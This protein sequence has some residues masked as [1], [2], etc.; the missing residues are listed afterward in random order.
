[1]T[2]FQTLLHSHI[3]QSRHNPHCSPILALAGSDTHSHHCRYWDRLGCTQHR[4]IGLSF[5]RDKVLTFIALEH[6]SPMSICTNT[7][8]WLMTR[9]CRCTLTPLCWLMIHLWSGPY[10]Y[11]IGAWST[12][13]EA[14]IT[15]A[16][17]YEPSGHRALSPSCCSTIHPW[18]FF[19][20]C[21]ITKRFDGD[22]LLIHDALYV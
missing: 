21:Q 6:G 19:S 9:L 11:R 5:V 13:V 14:N 12:C 4:R 3:L 16:S 20:R 10:F 8:V 22:I 17:V 18:W 2:L 15:V 1:M 7:A